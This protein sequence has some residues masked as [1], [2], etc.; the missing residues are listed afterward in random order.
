MTRMRAGTRGYLLLLYLMIYNTSSL[1]T[2]HHTTCTLGP[3]T[4][5]I[6][7]RCSKEDVDGDRTTINIDKD[8][9]G[10]KVTSLTFESCPSLAISL[11]LLNVETT[12]LTI[13]IKNS[14]IVNI[15]D[16]EFDPSLQGQQMLNIQLHNLENFH[17]Q[18]LQID[19][20]LMISSSNVQEIFLYKNKFSSLQ[21]PGLVIEKTK[22][23]SIIECV[24]SNIAPGAIDIN[25]VEEVKIVNSQ[26]SIKTVEAIETRNCPN[27]Y[28]SCNRFIE[29]P[30]NVECAKI[31]SEL[32]ISS[33][34]SSSHYLQASSQPAAYLN[35]K[36]SLE[37][38]N[39]LTT[40][41]WVL[42][43]LFLVIILL[44]VMCIFCRRRKSHKVGD[45]QIVFKDNV[46]TEKV[47]PKQKE[48]KPS[49][50]V[51]DLSNEQKGTDNWNVDSLNESDNGVGDIIE[52]IKQQEAIL[53][54]EIQGTKI[55]S[56]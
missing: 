9:I 41:L 31:S 30:I 23:L 49:S 32:Q 37:T 26:F 34:R 22:K 11:D 6:V 2:S 52:K 13:Q 45:V 21:P 55:Q 29:E 56:L 17:M 28:I 38:T 46:E 19:D 3:L 16:I 40:L 36:S 14:G 25:T 10:N 5:S 51:H 53:K 43:I 47:E 7:C 4:T 12:D 54:E 48:E 15:V 27:L 8:I 44:V 20:A 1:P 24:F 33:P 35:V 39:S 50:P 18:G 42:I